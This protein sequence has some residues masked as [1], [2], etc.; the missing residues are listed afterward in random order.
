MKNTWIELAKLPDL[1]KY[2]GDA[3]VHLANGEYK[4]I[5]YKREEG[6]LRPIMTTDGKLVEFQLWK[7]C[8]PDYEC[9]SSDLKPTVGNPIETNLVI[10]YHPDDVFAIELKNRVD[11][12]P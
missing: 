6:C 5:D 12:K 8:G 3:Y 9:L 4:K 11:I 1:M 10:R 2:T 7:S